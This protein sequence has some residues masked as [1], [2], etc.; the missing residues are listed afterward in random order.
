MHYG[1]PRISEFHGVLLSAASTTAPAAQI[2]NLP[3][4]DL[5]ARPI[6][7]SL[8]V[9]EPDLAAGLGVEGAP[10]WF[11]LVKHLHIFGGIRRRDLV[12]P[13]QKA[14]GIAIDE[15]CGDLYRFGAGNDVLGH[16]IPR[17]I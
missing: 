7:D 11:V 14:I 2:G 1:N 5:R 16:F 12:G 17:E 8:V 9:P 6:E 4:T 3:A 15:G 13:E 10:Q